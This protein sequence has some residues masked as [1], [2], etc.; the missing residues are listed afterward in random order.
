MANK[1]NLE[2]DE[3][4]MDSLYILPLS[5]I[6]FDTASLRK[7]RLLKNNKLETCIEL[8][9]DNKTG[10]GQVPI[11]QVQ[12]VCKCNASDS[13]LLNKLKTLPGYDVYSLRILFRQLAIPINEFDALK[14]SDKKAKELASYVSKFTRP[15]ILSIYG[16]D[17]GEIKDYEDLV[18]ILRNPDTKK[19]R[20]KLNL[21]ASKLN[22][23]IDEI[24]GFLESYAD[25][26]LS[27]SY[28]EKCFD[29]VRK[30]LKTFIH[31]MRDTTKSRQFKQDANF[32][33]TC[34]NIEKILLDI[35][36]KLERRFELFE[37]LVN[38]VWEDTTPENFLEARKLVES[39]HVVIG[40]SLCSLTVKMNEWANQFP[41]P[42][43]SNPQ[44]IAD[45][46]INDINPGI[47]KH[48]NKY[49]DELAEIE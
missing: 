18:N 26:F 29:T 16:D 22:I 10:S 41:S 7:A 9:S 20:K 48:I 46:I 40:G 21:M 11:D 25:L 3:V 38:S 49:S 13:V 34:E 1:S 24:P 45:F 23:S 27:V 36:A 14:L 47:N 15:L 35:E 33:K 43:S 5:I 6:P 31:A 44:R 8:F 32:A 19:V 42:E 39:S 12:T 4:D 30:H 37:K 17:Q 2:Y 28:F